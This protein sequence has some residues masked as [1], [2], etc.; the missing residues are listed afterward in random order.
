MTELIDGFAHIMPREVYHAFA[1][2]HPTEM[3]LSHDAEHFWDVERRV[4]DMDT[5]GID[6]QVL[7]LASPP[8]W[9]GIDRGDALELTRL[10]ND[11][12]ARIAERRQSR[13]IPTATL[14]FLSGEFLDEFDR[15]IEDLGVAGVQ[16]FSTVDG[17]PLDDEAFRPFFEKA[18]AADV[19]VWMHPQLSE[20]A[21]T[22]DS[23]FYAKVFGWLFDTSVALARLVFSGIMQQFPELTIIPHHMGGM[24]PHFADRIA[25]FYEARDFYPHEGWAE[26]DEPVLKYFRR[27][28]GDTVLNGSVSSLE[29]GYDFFGA[30]QLIFAT[31]Y[32]YGPDGGRKWL[33]EIPASIRRMD[34]TDDEKRQIIGGNLKR[35]IE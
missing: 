29:C 34:A 14:P 19:P 17:T 13:F 33:R 18:A 23:V 24:I 5:Y 27:F 20:Y 32:P 1:D 16:I 22:G 11:E 12:I 10:A 25:T 30:D 35:L 26:L 3:L 9:R 4:A 6:R 8:S 31:D 28:Y 2:T 15:C 21:I 7:T